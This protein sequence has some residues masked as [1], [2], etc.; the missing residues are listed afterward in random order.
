MAGQVSSDHGDDGEDDQGTSQRGV[1][2]DFCAEFA[3][4]VQ[5]ALYSDFHASREGDWRLKFSFKETFLTIFHPPPHPPNTHADFSHGFPIVLSWFLNSWFGSVQAE[6]NF[7]WFLIKF[8]WIYL[9]FYAVF[10]SLKTFWKHWIKIWC[11]VDGK[12]E[13]NSKRI[14]SRVKLTASLW[15]SLF[16][17]SCWAKS[18]ANESNWLSTS[19][20]S[21]QVMKADSDYVWEAPPRAGIR[22]S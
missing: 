4:L 7:N 16:A 10:F 9:D 12:R 5:R 15:L 17:V 6:W 19:R 21:N 20:R 8:L 11:L 3:Q 18:N 13:Q 14:S 22:G 1:A 2:V